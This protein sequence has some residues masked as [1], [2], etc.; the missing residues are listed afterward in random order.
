V[1]GAIV[2]VLSCAQARED[3]AAMIRVRVSG[4]HVSSALVAKDSGGRTYLPGL[5]RS[6]P[7]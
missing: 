5:S 4:L 7:L 6:P 3:I 2:V 1:V